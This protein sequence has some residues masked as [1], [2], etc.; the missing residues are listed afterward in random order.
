[1]PY[2]AYLLDKVM[3]KIA[4]I[5]I[6]CKSNRHAIV[7]HAIQPNRLLGVLLLNLLD[8]AS[9]MLRENVGNIN[10]ILHTYRLAKMRKNHTVVGALAFF[11][12]YGPL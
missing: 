3:I 7:L 5:C 12:I 9:M 1:M 8:T 4:R 10:K 6:H 2:S 11:T